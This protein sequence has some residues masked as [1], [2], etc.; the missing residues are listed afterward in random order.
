ML[1]VVT[2]VDFGQIG[3]FKPGDRLEHLQQRA[4][5]ALQIPRPGHLQRQRLQYSVH[6]HLPAC[7]SI[8]ETI[9][10]PGDP[11]QAARPRRG[12]NFAVLAAFVVERPSIVRQRAP[13]AA[14]AGRPEPVV[15]APIEGSRACRAA[16]L[17][18]AWRMLSKAGPMMAPGA[19]RLCQWRNPALPLTAPGALL[20]LL[21]C[22]SAGC[23]AHLPS[24]PTAGQPPVATLQQRRKPFNSDSCI[25]NFMD[26]DGPAEAGSVR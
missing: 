4:G 11:S 17:A 2:K 18:A 8:P 9:A 6:A 21:V 1:G 5:Q 16:L 3:G 12:T 20:I 19:H 15:S 7:M 13:F 23:G 25:T 22:L 24:H 26:L 14:N 10:N